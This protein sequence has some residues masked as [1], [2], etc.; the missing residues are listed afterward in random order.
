ML[1]KWF[2]LIAADVEDSAS[3]MGTEFS[4]EPHVSKAKQAYVAG[5]REILVTL[6][7]A[8]SVANKQ[9]TK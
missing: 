5:K 6:D 7:A 9:F 3:S 8:V 2:S 4:E 1:A